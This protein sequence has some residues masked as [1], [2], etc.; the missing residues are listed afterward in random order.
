MPLK[1][2]HPC[3]VSHFVPFRYLQRCFPVRL[4]HFLAAFFS[5]ACIFSNNHSLAQA[6]NGNYTIG[7]TNPNFLSINAA[8]QQLDSVGVSGPVT[9]WI[10]NGTYPEVLFI[11]SVNGASAINTITFRSESGDSSAVVINGT[12][13]SVIDKTLWL[14]RVAYMRFHQLTFRQLASVHNRAVVFVGR[15]HNITLSNCVIWGHLS[16]TSSRTITALQGACDSNYLVENCVIRGAYQ[17]LISAGSSFPAQQ[18][19]IFRNNYIFGIATDCIYV[20]GGAFAKITGNR[21]EAG[22]GSSTAAILLSG[23][24]RAQVVGNRISILSG[25]QNSHGIQIISSSG[26]A[27]EPLLV[28][29]NEISFTA[30]GSPIAY[31]IRASGSYHHYVHNT[32]RMSGGVYSVAL[33]LEV[34][35]NCRLFNNV[36]VHE[37]TLVGNH[38]LHLS[39]NSQDAVS[40]Y[41]NLY[42]AGPNLTPIHTTLAAYQSATGRDSLS[43]SVP[44]QFA[45][46]SMLIPNAPA[47]MNSGLLLPEVPTDING[48]LRNNPP[49]LGAYE[50]L[51]APLVALGPDTS[52]CD[53]FVLAVPAQPGTQWLWSTGD[54]LRSLVIR[55]S[56]TYWLQGTN[57]IG[58]S[59]DTVVVTILPR[60]IMQLGFT[61]DTL[62]SGDCVTLQAQLSGGSGN[63]NYLWQPATG[64]NNAQIANPTAC[65]TTSTTYRLLVTDANGCSVLSDSVH[66]RVTP[67]A[68]LS[69][70]PSYAGCDGD[71]ILLEATTAWTGAQIRWEPA[72]W[73]ENPSQA[74]T[75]AWPPPG[76]RTFVALAIHSDGCRDTAQQLIRISALPAV[77]MISYQNGM[78]QS[79]AS[80]G[81]QWFLNDS[82]LSGATA[83]TFQPVVNGRYRVLVTD[84][85]GC[86]STSAEFG[87]QNVS[88]RSLDTQLRI[89]PNPAHGVLHYETPFAV[90]RLAIA[91]MFGR[92]WIQENG[93]LASSGQLDVQ[94]LPAGMYILRLGLQNGT[95]VTRAWVKQ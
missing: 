74:R 55:N 67:P 86:S 42:T 45:S 34:T 83:S 87:L 93:S 94:S 30:G 10:R 78:L 35:N 46:T 26:W 18:R 21:I 85:A 29:N 25:A 41:N 54:T 79:S 38:A 84:S 80:S 15:G 11:D 58:V 88:I 68:Q 43:V 50:Q 36:L 7:G 14:N 95:V 9:F 44:P 71:T 31:G 23:H 81:N 4:A 75:R 66:L 92:T 28:A 17:G 90:T 40:N 3:I 12:T 5:I 13:N 37:G 53:S 60:P 27:N 89:W 72:L 76:T 6:L 47:L 64:L 77:P 73:I 20:V 16:S 8:V 69:V 65:P 62:C 51:T 82:L 63:F 57:S 22:G 19:P 70:G 1:S 61:A 59:R 49:D 33:Q 2:V 91:D 48:L 24:S 32:V 56:G 39:V 52:A